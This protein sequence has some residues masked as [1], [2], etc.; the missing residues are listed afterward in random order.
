MTDCDHLCPF[1]WL[2]D[3]RAALGSWLFAHMPFRWRHRQLMRAAM[4]M[5]R[6]WDN[7]REEHA[8]RR[9]MRQMVRDQKRV[10]VEG[11]MSAIR[12]TAE[13]EPCHD[14]LSVLSFGAEDGEE[15]LVQ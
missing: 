13:G 1:C 6:G 9:S 5:R 11:M 3:H 14:S 12:A 8:F 15:R 7:P 4:A 2:R 10:I